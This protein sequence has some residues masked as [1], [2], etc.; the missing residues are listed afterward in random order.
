MGSDGLEYVVGEQPGVKRAP[1][2]GASHAGGCGGEDAVGRPL[3]APRGLAMLRNR[4]LGPPDSDDD[5]RLAWDA[6]AARLARWWSKVTQGLKPWKS[7]LTGPASSP[8][9]CPGACRT[10]ALHGEPELNG[11]DPL[12][13]GDRSPAR[14]PCR[15]SRP[16][17]RLRFH[18]RRLPRMWGTSAAFGGQPWRHLRVRQRQKPRPLRSPRLPG[19]VQRAS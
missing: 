12:E 11:N 10:E 17:S 2:D 19:F 8:A 1:N 14:V 3:R 5:Q 18:E 7:V 16:H 13:Q 9:T 6:V 4:R 15:L